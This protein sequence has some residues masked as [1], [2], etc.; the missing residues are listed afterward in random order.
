MTIFPALYRPAY[1]PYFIVSSLQGAMDIHVKEIYFWR[2]VVTRIDEIFSLCS[3]L[4]TFTCIEPRFTV[5][6]CMCKFYLC[7][8]VP[9][10]KFLHCAWEEYKVIYC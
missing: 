3:N 6:L 2:K 7:M 5:N 1:A 4:E 9:I 8:N 10:F